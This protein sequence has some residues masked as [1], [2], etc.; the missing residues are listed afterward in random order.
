[1][2]SF[3]PETIFYIGKFPITN[4]IINT[5][6]VDGF[7]LLLAYFA[8]S[9]LAL[10]PG[11]FQNTVEIVIGGLHDFAQTVAGEKTK[12]IFPFFMTFLLFILVAN[13]SG[14]IPGIGT[15]GIVEEVRHDGESETTII[16]LIRPLTSD[17][18]ATFALAVVSLFATH[19]LA[20]RELGIKEYLTK[21]FAF[22]PLI[23]SILKGKPNINIDTK[24]PIDIIVSVVTPLVMVF[25]GFLELIS[26]FVKAISLSF[27]LFGNIYA[28]EV[29]LHTI[30]GIF[31]FLIPIPFLLL[32]VIVGA[33]QALVFAMLTMAFMVL[34]SSS[35]H[36]DQKATGPVADSEKSPTRREGSL[37]RGEVSH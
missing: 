8:R 33:V 10:I 31:A 28:G 9:K 18:N 34:L 1:M 7:L 35:H 11:K 6:L 13:W 29:V 12:N 3:A 36:E 2:A 23:I 22:I 15:F 4:T 24:S 16:P 37:A 20:I 14:L 21:F 19:I 27:R 32:E 25:V 30:Q 26:E 5:I 17:L